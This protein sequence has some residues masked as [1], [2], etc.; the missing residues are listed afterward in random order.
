MMKTQTTGVVTPFLHSNGTSKKE[1]L[2]L[3]KAAYR[4]LIPV[5]GALKRM[6]PN[7]RD[8]YPDPGRMERA[9]AQHTRRIEVVRALME[10]LEQ[11]AIAIDQL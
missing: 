9:V 10:E 4:A 6:A 8:Y 1:L 7:G 11:E 2:D 5:A 3:R